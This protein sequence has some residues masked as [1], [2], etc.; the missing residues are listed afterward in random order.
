MIDDI[1]PGGACSGALL[2][3]WNKSQEFFCLTHSGP[4]AFN[5]IHTAGCIDNKVYV[6]S[7]VPGQYLDKKF[8]IIRPDC[9]RQEKKQSE[10]FQQHNQFLLSA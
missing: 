1:H 2:S 8:R 5:S 3:S 10:Y 9:Q 6:G 4:V 7:T